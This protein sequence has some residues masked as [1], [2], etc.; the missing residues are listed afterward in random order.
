MAPYIR[1]FLSQFHS[2]DLLIFD[3]ICALYS[4]L[5]LWDGLTSD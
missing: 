2:K 4:F 3:M 5:C 1:V